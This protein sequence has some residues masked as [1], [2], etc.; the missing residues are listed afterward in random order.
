MK[1]KPMTEVKAKLSAILESS[2]TEPILI[3]RNGKPAGLLL[4]VD[5][6]TD[7][8]SIV[9]ANSPVFQEIIRKSEEQIRR[10]E[11]ISHEELWAEF[12]PEEKAKPAKGAKRRSKKSTPR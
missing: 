8:E 11:T 10:G 4:H 9:L 2:R 6:E 7:L 3:T 12:V 1:A 5:E